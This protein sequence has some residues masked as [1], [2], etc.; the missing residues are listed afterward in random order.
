[1]EQNK[2]GY[3]FTKEERFS[4][5]L[6][7]ANKFGSTRDIPEEELFQLGYL[8]SI[9][10]DGTVTVLPVERENEL[11]IR[12][13]EKEMERIEERPF[14]EVQVN[15]PTAERNF[16]FIPKDQYNL[17]RTQLYKVES[18]L[19]FNW[20]D[21][22]DNIDLE[23]PSEYDNF[24]YFYSDFIRFCNE[25]DLLR[26]F[27]ESMETSIESTLPQRGKYEDTD[28]SNAFD[29]Y[30]YILR[31]DRLDGL[32]TTDSREIFND[33]T[34]IDGYHNDIEELQKARANKL[35]SKLFILEGGIAQL[36]DDSIEKNLL[37][38][39]SIET[40][41]DFLRF[42]LPI[43]LKQAN[44]PQLAEVIRKKDDLSKFDDEFNSF[45]TSDPWKEE[46]KELK[47]KLRDA[48]PEARIAL[49]ER[50][51]EIKELRKN[52]IKIKKGVI[53]FFLSAELYARAG[54]RAISEAQDF[55]TVGKD[56]NE[57]QAMFYLDA[58]YNEELDADPG[59]ISG[60]CTSGRPLPFNR[61]EI[62]AYNIKVF[63]AERQHCGNMYL[64]ATSTEDNVHKVWHLDAIQIPRSG[65]DWDSSIGEIIK[66]LSIQAEIKGVDAITVNKALHQISNYDFIANAV[67]EYW[68][69]HG[70][71]T[72]Y[73][74]MPQNIPNSYSSFQGDGDA[75]V[76]WSSED[77]NFQQYSGELEG[78]T[79]FF[80]PNG[81]PLDW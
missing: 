13:K 9:S 75:I 78:N 18:A 29:I 1:M 6:E 60:D 45:D 46:E 41:Q 22:T 39:K 20:I 15:L 14:G 69:K 34:R 4:K 2:V 56:N 79:Q 16:R 51:K 61:V 52:R 42:V 55:L 59:E 30:D 63:S 17:Y 57:G 24:K 38:E 23:I 32:S 67:K 81:Q 68:E 70:R 3:T 25:D 43:Y 50:I 66:M 19:N 65:I 12:K 36:E 80:N 33:L 44:L 64:I 28:S 31:F 74:K 62:P 77:N 8:R 40:N 47:T 73:V 26:L 71:M 21:E 48:S 72:T 58:T 7:L 76:L 5:M 53:D 11:A 49:N 27:S 35:R 54:K 10:S 37:N